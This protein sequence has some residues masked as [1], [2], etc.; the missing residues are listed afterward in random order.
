MSTSCRPFTPCIIAL[1]CTACTGL[2]LEREYDINA[3]TAESAKIFWLS[4]F[5]ELCV[6][7]R[8]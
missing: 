3:E 5:R 2:A 1:Q 6:E 7:R 4:E 8:P